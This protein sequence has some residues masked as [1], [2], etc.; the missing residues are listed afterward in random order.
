MVLC[1]VVPGPGVRILALPLRGRVT[2][3]MF[4]PVFAQVLTCRAE[5][6]AP[7]ATEVVRR[8]NESMISTIYISV[9]KLRVSPSILA[10]DMD[11]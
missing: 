10:S 11:N 6:T 9:R 5:V 7:P 2:L 3:D 1:V 8:M 4:Q